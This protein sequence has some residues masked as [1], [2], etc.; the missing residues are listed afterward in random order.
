MQF[1]LCC[2]VCNALGIVR[3]LNIALVPSIAVPVTAAIASELTYGQRTGTATWLSGREVSGW[4][5]RRPRTTWCGRGGSG[6]WGGSGPG[7]RSR[8]GQRTMLEG[9]EGGL[10]SS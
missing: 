9:V 6:G 10:T 5:G 2:R 3:G 8:C 1:L 7:S 4:G